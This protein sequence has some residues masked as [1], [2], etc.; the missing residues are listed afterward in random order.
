M[1]SSYTV[2][3]EQ[4]IPIINT[5]HYERKPDL[6]TERNVVTALNLLISHLCA[7]AG[8]LANFKRGL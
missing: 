2:K 1:T 8:N 7:T 6:F 4:I 5:L 3:N